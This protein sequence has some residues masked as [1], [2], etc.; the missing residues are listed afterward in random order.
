M[1]E[2]PWT[3]SDFRTLGTQGRARTPTNGR[4]RCRH[5]RGPARAGSSEAR[6]LADPV[7]GRGFQ[8]PGC[9]RQGG[10]TRLLSAETVR[11]IGKWRRYTV[12]AREVA[13]ELEPDPDR[14][15]FF[16]GIVV[17]GA[18]PDAQVQRG[19]IALRARVV[20]S[21]CGLQ[22]V[23][24]QVSHFSSTREWLTPGAE[25]RLEA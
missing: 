18:A 11:V 12:L 9:G 21:C 1:F 10:S 19:G 7:V 5:G 2:S 15:H 4:R 23:H 3:T 22:T 20:R 8:P 25:M 13:V 14:R 6:G 24:Q 17:V 16:G